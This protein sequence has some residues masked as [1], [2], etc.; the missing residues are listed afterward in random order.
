MSLNSPILTLTCCPIGYRLKFFFFKSYCAILKS[1]IFTALGRI[2]AP[3][4][5]TC[6]LT[7]FVIFIIELFPLFLLFF[8]KNV[9]YHFVPFLKIKF[10]TASVINLFVFGGHT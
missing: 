5:W 9:F 1:D 2:N 3:N 7:L 10:S 8:K 6:K 4:N